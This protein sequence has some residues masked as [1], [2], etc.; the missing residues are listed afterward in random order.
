MHRKD[1]LTFKPS[2]EELWSLS[3]PS[4]PPLVTDG[5]SVTGG[6]PLAVAGVAGGSRV[7]SLRCAR[8]TRQG[9]EALAAGFSPFTRQLRLN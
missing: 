1:D 6:L 9:A 2:G 8:V 3:T 7:A 4:A 5:P